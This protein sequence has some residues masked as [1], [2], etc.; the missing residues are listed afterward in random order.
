V[1]ELRSMR[2][3]YNE[4]TRSALRERNELNSKVAAII[5]Q[6]KEH[7]RLRDSLNETVKACKVEREELKAQMAILQEQMAELEKQRDEEQPEGRRIDIRRIQ[8]RTEEIEW[9]MQTTV[10]QPA[11][12]KELVEELTR[13]NETLKQASVAA[14]FHKDFMKARRQ[15]AKHRSRMGEIHQLVV[16]TA[17]RSQEHHDQMTTLFHDVNILRKQAN[18]AHREFLDN[19][20]KSDVAHGR[21]VDALKQKEGVNTE[22]RKQKQKTQ[23]DRAK[24][25][26]Q[27]KQDQLDEAVRKYKGGQ[28]LSLEEFGMLVDKGLI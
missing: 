2:D 12:E 11:R 5:E 17:R 22:I 10:I 23:R 28:K 4:E 24:K 25:T 19:K 1:K 8:Q 21:F 9:R 15:L 18:D 26:R 7:M 27:V 3:S 16:H 20:R 13:L 14:E 6:A